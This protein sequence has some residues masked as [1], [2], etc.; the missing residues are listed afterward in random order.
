[1]RRNII[2]VPEFSAWRDEEIYIPDINGRSENLFLFKSIYAHPASF[3]R[4]SFNV[5][6]AKVQKT[7]ICQ[8]KFIFFVKS[9]Y[10]IV[11]RKEIVVLT[12]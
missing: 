6:P 8:F 2:S 4:V 5:L 9:L 10:V 12:R 11:T 1:M 7:N 3:S